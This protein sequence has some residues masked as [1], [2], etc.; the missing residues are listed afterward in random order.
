MYYSRCINSQKDLVCSVG[1]ERRGQ[2]HQ[3]PGK[4]L[5][6]LLPTQLFCYTHGFFSQPLAWLQ[7]E[8]GCLV[9]RSHSSR[10]L[11]RA[12]ATRLHA[13]PPSS[14][15]PCRS[16]TTLAFSRQTTAQDCPP[17]SNGLPGFDALTCPRRPGIL[18]GSGASPLRREA[19]PGHIPSVCRI[20]WP[21]RPAQLRS[22]S[23]SAQPG[24]AHDPGY[25]KALDT[26][27]VPSHLVAFL[28][29][30]GQKSAALLPRRLET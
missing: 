18:T 3:A 19:L 30:G 4:T 1:K 20:I 13:A 5:N 6:H 25:L 29:P 7:Q 26:L 11:L 14:Q 15:R 22:L 12:V 16:P 2:L 27:V 17:P 28:G 21:L 24:P 9:P 8:R 23:P 10:A